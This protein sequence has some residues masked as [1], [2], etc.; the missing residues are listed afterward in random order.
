MISTGL[1]LVT[2]GDVRVHTY[3]TYNVGYVRNIVCISYTVC[4]RMGV[5]SIDTYA[6]NTRAVSDLTIQQLSS[7]DSRV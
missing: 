4:I 1:V 7:S 5:D 3:C 2:Y 6:C